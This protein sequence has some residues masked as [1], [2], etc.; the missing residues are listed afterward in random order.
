MEDKYKVYEDDDIIIT[1]KGTTIYKKASR[2]F[3]KAL[4]ADIPSLWDDLDAK[5]EQY[6]LAI[7][8]RQKI[9]EGKHGN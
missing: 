3:L 1:E 5:T 8:N 7:R 9:Q 6:Q 2:K 4:T